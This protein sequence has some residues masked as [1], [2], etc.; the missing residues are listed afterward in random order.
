MINWSVVYKRAE[1]RDG[2]LLFPE[3]LTKEFLENARKVMGSYW[4]ANQYLNE[5]IPEDL[6]NF[7]KHWFKYYS[8]VPAR[9]N[10]FV[11]IDPAISQENTADYTGVV[12]VSVDTED[13][14]Y[15]RFAQRFRLTP[16]QIID[17]MFR[18]NEQ[19]K[20]MVVGIETVAYQEALLYMLDQEMRR[21]GQLLP[22]HGV[23]HGTSESKQNRILGLVPRFEWGRIHLAQGLTV[24]EDELL[25]FPRGGHDDVIDALASIEKIAIRPEREKIKDEQPNPANAAQYESW[26]RRQLGKKGQ[27]QT[28]Q[29]DW[30]SLE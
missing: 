28:N 15:V 19:F 23:K 13:S 9:N 30:N 6:Q 21:R 20:P 8:E 22:V 25:K 4:Y 29:D 11:F 27:G 1:E 10:T 26:Y 7:K 24:L 18:L 12:V 3:R 16:T 5:I 2:S 14:W 17:L